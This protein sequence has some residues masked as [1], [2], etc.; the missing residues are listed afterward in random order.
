[1]EEFACAR[2]PGT[3]EPM[4]VAGVTLEHCP[5]CGGVFF[6]SPDLARVLTDGSVRTEAAGDLSCPRCRISMERLPSTVTGGFAYQLCTACHG[7][8]LDSAEL[9]PF[10]RARTAPPTEIG[11]DPQTRRRRAAGVVEQL[12]SLIG[13][14]ERQRADRL[15]RLE[16]LAGFGTSDAR[17][18]RSLRALSEAEA[19]VARRALAKSPLLE[20]ARRFCIEGLITGAQFESIRE[21]LAT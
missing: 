2:C 11:R 21:R 12:E 4:K 20:E 1:M 19:T 16:K 6:E 17:E 5:Q 7:L 8:W 18:I 14:I 15:S 10:E 13:S 9:A 3:L